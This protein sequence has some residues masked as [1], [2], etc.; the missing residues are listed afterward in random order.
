M[1]E[2]QFSYIVVDFPILATKIFFVILG[3]V[4]RSYQ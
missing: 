4:K 3:I 1:D 2:S